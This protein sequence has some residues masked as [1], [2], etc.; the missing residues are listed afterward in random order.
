MNLS[1]ALEH[2]NA[3]VFPGFLTDAEAL[4]AERQKNEEA[5]QLLMDAWRTSAPGAEPFSFDLVRNLADRN[6]TTCD[7]YG[8]EL[9]R[10]LPPTS[11]SR[12][13][14]DEDLIRSVAALQHRSFD[15][16]A[17]SAG[18]DA[19]D[20]ATAYVEAPVSG[21]ILGIDIETTDRDPSRGYIINVGLEFM[22]LTPKAK[23]QRPFMGYCG[24]PDLYREKGVPLSFVHH[25]GWAQLEGRKPFRQDR[26]MQEAL[27]AA[28]EAF[29]YMAHNA[30]FE[31]SWFMLQLDGYAEARKAGRIVPIDTRDI[32]R[33][34]DPEYKML[35]HDSRP[36][37]LESWA[38][39]RGT[40]KASEKEKH[41]GLEDVDLMF[42]TVQAEFAERNMFAE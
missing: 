5:I 16:V 37:A 42:R 12:K 6:R 10:D 40:L 1:Q 9:L 35:P 17:R 3:F 32:C 7:S 28:M 36:A 4:N 15:E 27:L 25:I 34:V 2:A 39:R 23:P 26:K 21:T 30:A 19:R 13:L 31:D 22:E 24:L 18:P 41:L 29:P 38:R 11:L 33:R 14:S 8:T 20:L